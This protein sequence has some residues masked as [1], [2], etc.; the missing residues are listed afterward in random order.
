[1][2]DDLFDDEADRDADEELQEHSR[3]I[4]ELLD[5]YADEHDLPADVMSPLAFEVG[6]KL[7]MVAYCIGTAKPS[8]SGLKVELDRCRRDLDE[9]IRAHKKS[10]DEFVPM[11]K[12]IIEEIER[13]EEESGET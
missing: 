5:A 11:T 2:S 7:R 6:L 10:A 4:H 8:G 9:L 12:E 13:R 1:M 3:A